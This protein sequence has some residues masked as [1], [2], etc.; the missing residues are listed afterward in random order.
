MVA[1]K[2]KKKLAE[3]L[4]VAFDYLIRNNNKTV[5]FKVSCGLICISNTL[6]FVYQIFLINFFKAKM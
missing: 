6:S 4:Q 5:L 2:K 1:C 3:N